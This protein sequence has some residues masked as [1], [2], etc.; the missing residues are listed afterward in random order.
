MTILL[1]SLALVQQPAAAPADTAQGRPC[2]IAIDSLPRGR[3]VTAGSATNYFG[4]GG[5]RAHCKGTSTTFASESIQ[6]FT[7]QQ[8]FDMI[9]N[10]HIRDTLLELDANLATYFLRDE[11]LEAHNRVVAVNRG[12]HSVLRG[13]NL[14][15]YRVVPGV[16]DTTEMTATQR[17]TIE[18][19]GGSAPDSAEPYIIV[20]DRVRFRGND[21]MWGGGK[22][23]IDRSDLAARAD[24]LMLDQ[25]VGLGVLLGKPQIAGKEAGDTTRRYTLIGT[26]IELAFHDRDINLVKALGEGKATGSDW[27]LTADTIHLHIDQRKLQQALA[28]GKKSRPHAV[29][30]LQ[31]F[32][33]DSLALDVPDEVLT[34]ARGFGTAFSTSKR[35]SLA[36]AEDA[37]WITGD[38]LVAHWAQEKDSTGVSRSRIRQILAHGSARALTHIVNQDSTAQ[39]P[40]INYSRGRSITIA[41]KQARIDRVVV[42]GRADGVH[43]EPRPP[44]PVDTTKK[45][46]AVR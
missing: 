30:T 1:L 35:D 33:A 42:G 20:A 28:W 34:E 24:S 26:R 7:A 17:P 14:T 40:S 37:D 45:P 39:G 9:G 41:L 25:R 18:Y 21:R 10:V 32:S 5:V 46:G 38:T 4:G 16:R 23:T 43:L 15:Y 6:Y 36:K 3:Q 13:P 44:A 12:N 27:T 31:T 19:R 8:R 22:V 11:R 2:V 29:S